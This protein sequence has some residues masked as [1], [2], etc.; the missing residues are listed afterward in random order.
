M[1]VT[2]FLDDGIAANDA[3]LAVTILAN[4]GIDAIEL[5]GGTGWGLV[6]LG[7]LNLSPMRFVKDEGYYR[8]TARGIKATVNIPVI[9]TGGIRSYQTADRF[10]H[11]GIADYIGLCRPLIREPDLINRWKSGDTSPSGCISDNGCV[12]ALFAGKGIVCTQLVKKS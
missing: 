6:V 1:N 12:M 9:L 3:I 2:D 5:S 8:D 7:D 4:N 10:L 11:E